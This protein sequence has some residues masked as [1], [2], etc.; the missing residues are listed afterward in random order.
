[1]IVTPIKTRKVTASALTLLELLDES[2]TVLPERSVVAITSKVVSLCEGRAVPAD[3]ADPEELLRREADYYLPAD[4][5]HYG[6]HFTITRGPMVAM[7]CID[8]SNGH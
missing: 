3:G 2:L 4:F 1:M 5:S 8:Q 7:A 6:F